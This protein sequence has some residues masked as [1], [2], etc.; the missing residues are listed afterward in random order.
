VTTTIGGQ[1]WRPYQDA[2]LLTAPM[3]LGPGHADDEDERALRK[4]LGALIAVRRAPVHVAVAFNAV[5]F[6]YDLAE[7]GYV[8]GPVDLDSF[9]V[10]TFGTTTDAL[11]V[12]AMVNVVAGGHP[13]FAEVVYKEG[14]HPQLGVDGYVPS[15]LSGAPAGATG[16]YSPLGD[17][18]TPVLTERLVCDFDAFGQGISAARD[19]LDRFRARGRWLDADGHLLVEARYAAAEA[20]ELDDVTFYA[21][22]LLGPARDRLLSFAAPQPL[23]SML[24]DTA[25]DDQVEQALL[26]LLGT[27]RAALQ[28]TAGVR[29]WRSY[30]FTKTSLAERLAADGALGGEDLRHVASVL[31]N[32]PDRGRRFASPGPQVT[33]T[34]VGPRL[35][36]FSGAEAALR[37]LGYPAVICHANT[38]IADYLAEHGRIGVLASASHVRLDDAWQGGG[39]W[40][41]EHPAGPYSGISPL[42][43]LGLGWLESQTGQQRAAPSDEVGPDLDSEVDQP[44]ETQL[45][46]ITDSQLSW[47]V[48]LRLVHLL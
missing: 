32:A 40:R 18:A 47:V 19:R 14:A 12:G 23:L 20:A 46:G 31:A 33:Y 44:D 42:Q 21:A 2:P 6:G 35:R 3:T 26:G 9:P 27:I 24:T 48:P 25:G 36:Q 5:F 1:P 45:L 30:A 28:T 7:D 37:G 43:A 22:Y 10:V 39:V 11:P 15:W 16:P 4:Y 34:A 38:V 17:T 8:G 29:M 13:L 41:T